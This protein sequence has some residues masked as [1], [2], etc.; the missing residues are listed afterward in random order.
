MSQI[1]DVAEAV[2]N[3]TA[4]LLETMED[5]G[6][7]SGSATLV[8][9]EYVIQVVILKTHDSLTGPVAKGIDELAD[10]D[11]VHEWASAD[12]FRLWAGQG[13]PV[14]WAR[15][16]GVETAVV[17][18]ITDSTSCGVIEGGPKPEQVL[19]WC[20]SR[21]KAVFVIDALRNGY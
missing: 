8:V 4:G 17:Y 9:D 7:S 3:R 5:T 10:E 14:A 2:K 15:S 18:P 21:E 1:S 16:M 20:P 19:C 11:D 13:L 12:R 6:Y